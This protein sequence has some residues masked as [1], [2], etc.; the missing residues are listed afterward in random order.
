M[1]GMNRSTFPADLLPGLNAHFGM[2]YRELPEEW[3]EVFMVSNSKKPFEEDVL[4]VGLGLAKIKGEGESVA[5][6]AG[7]QGWRARYL[8]ETIALAFSIT[9]EA[10]EDNL[11]D[12]LGPKYARALARAL[13]QTKEIKCAAVFNNGFDSN[14]AGG[15]GKELFSTLHPL[16]G[17][18]TQ[19]NCLGTPADLS[20]ASLEDLLILIRKTKDDR[21]IP[22]ALTPRKLVV[23]PE[24][25]YTAIRLLQ[26]NL[27]PGTSDNDVNAI[28]NKGVFAND[29][30]VMTRL[31]DTDAFFITTDI[32]DG[33]KLFQRTAV[34]RGTEE[35][36]NTGNMRYKVRERF[37]VGFSDFRGCYASAGSA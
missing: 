32:P 30:V 4:E 24:L 34:Q 26:S 19:A 35:D 22:I 20:E 36:F 5:Y 33:L 9:Q 13:K 6:D 2:A 11:Y 37:S 18:G 16:Y 10:V 8:H 29:P 23:P 21:G 28:K 7:G 25:E 27:R 12:S 3:R 17:G 31:T 15:D 1:A 14:Y